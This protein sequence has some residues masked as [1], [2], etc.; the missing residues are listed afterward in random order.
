ML[1]DVYVVLCYVSYD[2][3]HDIYGRSIVQKRFNDML[4]YLRHAQSDY[5]IQHMHVL[6][7]AKVLLAD[8]ICKSASAGSK[9]HFIALRYNF[10]KSR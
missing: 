7:H 8:H 10:N 3:T 6:C 9:A 2:M 4:L 5:F 1:S